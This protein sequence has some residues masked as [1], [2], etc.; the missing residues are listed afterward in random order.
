MGKEN[1]R[2][3]TPERS[4]IGRNDSEMIWDL[5]RSTE[6]RCD[7]NVDTWRIEKIFILHIQSESQGKENG[8]K[9]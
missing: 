5:I 3:E 7:R 1:S 2:Q 9:W 8:V 4:C 6:E